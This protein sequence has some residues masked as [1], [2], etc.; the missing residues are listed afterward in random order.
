MSLS[1]SAL[2]RPFLCSVPAL[3]WGRVSED[4]IAATKRAGYSDAKIVE[5]VAHVVLNTFG[6]Y[7]NGTLKT[8]IDFPLGAPARSPDPF[9]KVEA[10][11]PRRTTARR[12]PM[13]HAPKS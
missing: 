11:Q 2:A 1:R 4:D 13:S 3:V 8:E 6:D 5:V 12:R 7:A 10:M 9:D